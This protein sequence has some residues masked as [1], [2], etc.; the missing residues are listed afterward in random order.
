M[1]LISKIRARATYANVTATLALFIAL[2]GGSFAVALSGSE[3]KVVKKIAKKEA[4][5]RITTRAP[6]LSVKRAGSADTA[7]DAGHASSA[8]SAI[9]ANHANAADT[10]TSADSAL[11]ANHANAAD[12][13]T[14][15][16]VVDGLDS[17]HFGVGI[18]GG[19][20]KDV[21][22][23]AVANGTQWAPIGVST[24]TATGSFVAPPGAFVARDLRISLA[25]PNSAGQSRTFAFVTNPAS[26]TELSCTVPENASSCSDTAHAVTV[27]AGQ[28]Y[29]LLATAISGG[30]P[31]VDVRFGW[32][33]VSP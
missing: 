2:G 33:A 29:A 4:N 1:A 14:N 26:S 16:D 11:N 25:S 3:K 5:K 18:M 20:M 19:V 17:T 21:G 28:T 12:T 23:T 13:A 31:D 6:N 22:F 24:A 27:S 9:D 30:A 10:A 7:T 8:D 32:R 15:A